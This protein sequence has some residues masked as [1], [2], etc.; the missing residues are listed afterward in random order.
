[1]I[2]LPVGM[3]IFGAALKYELSPVVLALGSFLVGASAFAVVPVTV[4]YC[5][6][7]FTNYPT[8]VGIIMNFYRLSFG[9]TT[10]Y[11]VTPWSAQVGIG[12]VFGMAA[13]FSL[14]SF[15][16]VVM[17]LLKGPAIRKV[18]YSGIGSTEEGRDLY[19]KGNIS[20]GSE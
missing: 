16:L 15:G 13:I 5:I 11:F 20:P 1:M 10:S 8:E 7:C 18:Q 3:G 14:F 19:R 4:N 12:W 6:E 17:L 2:G 9:T